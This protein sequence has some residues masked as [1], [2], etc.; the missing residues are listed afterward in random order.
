MAK[1][2]L[3]RHGQTDW[4]NQRRVQGSLDIPLN[5]EGKKEAQEI[6]GELSKLEISAVYSGPESC[7]VATANEIAVPH[8]VRVQ[9]VRALSELNHGVWQGLLEEDIKKRYKKQYNRLER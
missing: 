3:I 9:K 7:N 6:A 5:N 8:R 4:S 1:L 2:I